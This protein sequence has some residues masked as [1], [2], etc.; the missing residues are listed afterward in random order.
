MRC[1]EA[2]GVSAL[3]DGEI[4]GAERQAVEAHIAACPVCTLMLNDFRGMGK[5]LRS[6]A[7]ELA[8]PDLDARIRSQLKN[9]LQNRPALAT[10]SWSGLASHA[11]ALLVVASLS[12]VMGWWIAGMS[13]SQSQI[14]SDVIAAHVRSLLQDSPF[15]I[16]SS[17]SHQV[18]PWFTGRLDY[19]PV[20]KDLAGEG[21]PLKG[22]RLDY[23][24][25][26]RVSAI[27]YMR[28]M[29][30]INVFMW[31]VDDGGE[32]PVPPGALKGYNVLSWTM[33]GV[34]YWAVSDLNIAELQRFKALL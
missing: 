12:G 22:A 17:D 7:Y 1:D 2:D 26:R 3:V 4:H 21:F 32:R 27:V 18:K 15:Q 6:A 29:H 8:P 24:N 14:Q 30:V 33:G 16:A 19:A 31:P 5:K 11:A 9:S 20:V 34:I 13:Q 28:R 23:V 10:L 25:G